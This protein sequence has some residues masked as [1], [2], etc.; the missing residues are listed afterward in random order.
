MVNKAVLIGKMAQEF[1]FSHSVKNGERFFETVIDIKRPSGIVDSIPVLISE[2]TM[3]TVDSS[4]G[5]NVYVSG[6]F[7]SLKKDG[8]T[9][10]FILAQEFFFVGTDIVNF[11]GISCM[12]EIANAPTFRI[13]PKGREVSDFTLRSNR[14][15]NRTD[16]LPCIAWGKDAL[17]ASEI[18]KGATVS[19]MGHIQSRQYQKDGEIQTTYEI[20]ITH[21]EEIKVDEE[22]N[23]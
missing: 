9:I 15:Y 7:H 6:Q 19:I 11:N 5:G 4:R 16:Y 3:Q 17:L 8:K 2:E 21:M 1:A 10:Y 14:R 22:C 23:A 13:T 18:Q 12:G 20:V